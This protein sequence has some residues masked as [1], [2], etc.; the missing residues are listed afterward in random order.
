MKTWGVELSKVMGFGSD[1]ASV[2]M[3][4]RGGVVAKLKEENPNL[5]G[6]HCVAHRLAR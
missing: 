4:R 3:G 2:M 1:G 6:I 5:I